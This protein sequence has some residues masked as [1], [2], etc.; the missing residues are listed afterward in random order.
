MERS[1]G[2]QLGA[3]ESEQLLP[4]GI[5]EDGVMITHDGLRHTG[6]SDDGVKGL[7]DRH[8]EV[9]VTEG[10]EVCVHGEPVHHG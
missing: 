4:E 5:G 6:E 10:E 9:G 1:I 8:G 3:S 7:R 2:A